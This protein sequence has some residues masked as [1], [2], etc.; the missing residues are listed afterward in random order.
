MVFSNQTSMTQS[1]VG[2]VGKWISEQ[3]S[4]GIAQRL[5]NHTKTQKDQQSKEYIPLVFVEE[6]AQGEKR[7]ERS[8]MKESG[9][10]TKG[11]C[12]NQQL[13]KE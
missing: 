9:Y 1:K 8:K 13:H 2:R 3:R 6:S 7:T 10:K 11:M 4:E 12:A 5:R